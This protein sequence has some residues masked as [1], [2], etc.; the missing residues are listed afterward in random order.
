MI[1]NIFKIERDGV[2]FPFYKDNPK[3]KAVDWV[4]LLMICFLSYFK[5]L[6]LP[7]PLIICFLSFVVTLIITKLDISLFF[8]KLVPED[9][10]IIIVL[11]ILTI[12]LS[13]LLFWTLVN[14][15]LMSNDSG[16]YSHGILVDIVNL[17]VCLFGEELFKFCIFIFGLVLVYKLTSNRKVSIVFAAFLTMLLF[18]TYHFYEGYGNLLSF[19]I[20]Q[21]FGSIFDVLAYIKT[22]NVLV[23]YLIHLIFD[24]Y[25]FIPVWFIT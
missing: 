15:G 11:V 8:K 12:F 6:E 14:V 22:K 25:C 18:G 21:G 1:G 19:I 4:L 7:M 13:E 17:V 23:S 20:M 3:L 16:V 9:I 5:P 2:D 24:I 10:P